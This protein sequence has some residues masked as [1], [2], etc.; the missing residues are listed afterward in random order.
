MVFSLCFVLVIG[1]VLLNAIY[2]NTM[3]A[4]YTTE[5]AACFTT[6]PD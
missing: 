2:W 5:P 1:A 6:L 4:M 3:E